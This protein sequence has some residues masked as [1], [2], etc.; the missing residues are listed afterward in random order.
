MIAVA[1]QNGGACAPSFGAGSCRERSGGGCGAE[2]NMAFD[3]E[4]VVPYDEEAQEEAK[5]SSPRH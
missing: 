2:L 4:E 3:D 1:N 5:V